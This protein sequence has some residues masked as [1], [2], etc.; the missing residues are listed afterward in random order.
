M[1][2][3]PSGTWHSPAWPDCRRRR[4]RSCGW[5]PWSRPGPSC[6]CWRRPCDRR[7]RQWSIAEA[8]LLVIDEEAVGFRHELLRQA[9][10]GSL[11]ALGRRGLHRR[12]LRVLWGGQGRGVDI[13]RLVHHARQADDVN[14]VLRYAPEAARQAAAVAAHREAVGH[15][16]AVLPHA[17]RLSPPERAELLERYSVEAYLSG[18]AAEAV[19]ARQAALDLR[20]A[21]D[22][23]EKVG[24]GLR[25][26]SRLTWWAGRR[27]EA[28]AA[29]ARAIAV[30][31]TL[32]PGHQLAL[33]YSNQ[34]QLDMLASRTEAATDVGVAG[35][36]AGRAARRPGNA[37]PRPDQHRHRAA[38]RR[39]PWRPWP[40]EQAFEVAVAA[41]LDD[42]AAR[43]LVNLAGSTVEMRDYRHAR[44]DLDRA[45]TFVA[46]HDLAGYAHYLIGVRASMGL[47]LGDQAG[48]EQDARTALTQLEQRRQGG[49][50]AVMRW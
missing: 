47:D 1:C 45:L 44:S 17:D 26:L 9:V 37:D 8:G 3:P 39:R 21:A 12:V 24:E 38:V 34:A 27:K 32:E 18:L 29:A 28:E 50:G 48:A 14:A 42:H 25:W 41:G 20:E 10:E 31:G 16:R 35:E 13:A 46:E 19:S 23:Q 36:G 6:G 11:S 15:Y 30:L 33:A 43:A 22:D 40:L 4:R 5:W 49:I 2:P 7:R